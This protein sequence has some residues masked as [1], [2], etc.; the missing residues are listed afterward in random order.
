[1]NSSLSASISTDAMRYLRAPATDGSTRAL[2]VEMAELLEQRITPRYVFRV[3]PLAHRESG[4]DLTGT[5][6]ILPGSLARTMLQEC[7]AAALL[8]CT[9][10]AGFEQLLRSWQVRDMARA[11]VLDACGSAYVEAGCNAAEEEIRARC[12]GKYLTDRFSPG[13]G[14]LPLTLQGSIL[15]ALNAGRQLGL[16][17]TESCLLN[18]S[19]SVTAVIGLSSQ[20]QPARIRG[21]AACQFW[22]T[23]RCS[24]GQQ[25]CF[26]AT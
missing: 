9:L 2:V 26:C 18:P 8:A 16:Q 22:N 3:V 23:D 25:D 10:G 14:D 7:D 17:A 4:F 20:P 12:A 24:R 21:C 11:A 19:K 1:M 5:G 13:Y 15:E 6:V